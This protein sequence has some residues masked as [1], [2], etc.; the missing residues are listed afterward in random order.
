MCAI[1]QTSTGGVSLAQKRARLRQIT[2]PRNQAQDKRGAGSEEQAARKRGGRELERKE[3]GRGRKEWDG[4]RGGTA[5]WAASN[6]Q[7]E[8]SEQ[9]SNQAS[10]EGM[11]ARVAGIVLQFAS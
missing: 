4:V 11:I 10:K 2:W 1:S 8:E 9:A 3:K 6:G 5:M 7:R